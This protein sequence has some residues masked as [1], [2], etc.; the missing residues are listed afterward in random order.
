MTSARDDD[1][2]ST[3]D[4][5]DDRGGGAW[6]D[7]E[8]DQEEI[9]VVSLFDDKVFT[10]AKSMLEYCKQ[11]HGFDFIAI[12]KQHSKIHSVIFIYVPPLISL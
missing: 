5:L 7:A 8:P 6:E 1:S 2:S 4:E 9:R 3:S 12:Q 10:D 11:S